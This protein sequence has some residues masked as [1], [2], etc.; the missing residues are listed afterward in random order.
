MWIVPSHKALFLALRPFLYL[1]LISPSAIKILLLDLMGD[2][3]PFNPVFPKKKKKKWYYIEDSL[4][5]PHL[6]FFLRKK[7]KD[8][9]PGVLYIAIKS[10]TFQVSQKRS[11]QVAF[12]FHH[13]LS[14]TFVAKACQFFPLKPP[15]TG[16]FI[17]PPSSP[18]FSPHIW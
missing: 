2:F 15:Q 12:E 6:H 8:S 7:R 10:L 14:I 11:P 13:H 9:F 16:P 18:S 1:L 17:V 5:S 4:S 3:L